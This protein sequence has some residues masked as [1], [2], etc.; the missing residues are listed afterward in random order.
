MFTQSLQLGFFL[1]GSTG[2]CWGCCMGEWLV[3][4]ERAGRRENLWVLLLCSW[5]SAA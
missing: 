3:Q 2:M 5:C 1:S 4:Y